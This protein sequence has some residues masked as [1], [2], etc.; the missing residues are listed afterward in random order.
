VPDWGYGAITEQWL[1]NDAVL[2]FLRQANPWALRDMAERLLEA[3]HRGL[4]SGAQKN[5]LEH[6]RQLVLEAE[7]LVEG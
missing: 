5:Q 1:S 2:Q 7:A 4:W 6:L 3:H